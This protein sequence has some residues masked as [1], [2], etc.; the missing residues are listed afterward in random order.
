MGDSPHRIVIPFFNNKP[1]H[2]VLIGSA[3]AVTL[4]GYTGGGGL[5]GAIAAYGGPKENLD[6]GDPGTVFDADTMEDYQRLT[7]MDTFRYTQEIRGDILTC[8]RWNER[9]HSR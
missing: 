5:R 6:S 1:G 8:C 9:F 4:L 3:A 2:P 7:L